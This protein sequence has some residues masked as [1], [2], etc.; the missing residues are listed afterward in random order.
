MAAHSGGR[1]GWEGGGGLGTFCS[2]SIWGLTVSC[3]T[4]LE[5]FVF[6]WVRRKRVCVA[7]EGRFGVHTGKVCRSFLRL[8][9]GP[10]LCEPAGDWEVVCTSG[11]A[12]VDL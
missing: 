4:Y 10:V 3:L 5:V 7:T 1:V 6:S 2:S 11:I 12:A 9:L 8:I